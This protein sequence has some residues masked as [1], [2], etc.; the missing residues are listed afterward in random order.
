MTARSR[1]RPLLFAQASFMV[2]FSSVVPFFAALA[3]TRYGLGAAEVGAIVGTRVA[4]QQGMFVVGGLLADRF[5]A[6]R[7]LVLGCAVRA[8]GYVMLATTADVGGFVIGVILTGVAGALFSPAL[9][10]FVGAVDQHR[11]AEGT[12]GPGGFA[13]LAVAGEAGALGGA[14]IG[15]MLMPSASVPVLLGGALLFCIAAITLFRA[16]P[17]RA[18]DAPQAPHASSS[19]PAL[20]TR[21]TLLVGAGAATLLAVYTQLFTLIPWELAA[22]GGDA[23]LIGVVSITLSVATLILQWPLAH[24]ADRATAPRAIVL[25][26]GVAVLAAVVAGARS[27]MPASERGLS[28][29]ILFATVL[30]AVA[31][32]LGGPAAQRVVSAA[33]PAAQRAARLG[34]LAS[35]GGI[36]SLALSTVTG[37]VIGQAGLPVAWLTVAGVTLLG[38][39][40]A[41]SAVRTPSPRRLVKGRS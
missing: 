4:A 41:A 36:L 17:P 35:A 20:S 37:A 28:V 30:T 40:A 11:R 5:G 19:R 13:A 29:G 39:T 31:L 12:R 26:I 23:G 8:S 33:G 22:T 14:L 18:D 3:T 24:L 34:A 9:E 2:G 6:R 21:R 27:A 15:L 16:L 25:A 1:L 7:L 32:M 10:S 38:L